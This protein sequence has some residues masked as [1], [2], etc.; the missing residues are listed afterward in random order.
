MSNNLFL[1]E[2][3]KHKGKPTKITTISREPGKEYYFTYGVL[4]D[5]D[6]VNVVIKTKWGIRQITIDDIREFGDTILNY[7]DG[8]S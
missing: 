2:L 6:D 7:K 3:K 5:I 1:K 8:G 4:L